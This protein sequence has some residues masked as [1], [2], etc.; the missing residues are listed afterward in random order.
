MLKKE[1]DLKLELVQ[2]KLR[3]EQEKTK[4]QLEELTINQELE[5]MEA[6]QEVEV[7]NPLTKEQAFERILT[8][9]KE[10]NEVRPYD[11]TIIHYF[12]GVG[13]DYTLNGGLKL[14]RTLPKFPLLP[15]V[16]M[17]KEVIKKRKF[18]ARYSWTMGAVATGTLI[19]LFGM[20]AL[21][22][23]PVAL[24]SFSSIFDTT[25]LYRGEKDNKLRSLLSSIFLGKKSK[26][27]ISNYVDNLKELE[28]SK[29]SF[30]LLMELVRKEIEADKL[31]E[32][33]NESP[34]EKGNYIAMLDDG[35][36]V[37]IP[38]EKYQ[39]MFKTPQ[40]VISKD[41]KREMLNGL[42]QKKLEEFTTRE[43]AS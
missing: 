19:S 43:L 1:Y 22:F 30:G 25:R 38:K 4:L 3:L 14:V 26:K 32:I 23:I 41:E 15:K 35:R 42:L 16:Q 37:R 31:L 39:K 36:F 5:K 27:I 18:F 6:K 9:E 17:T 8:L 24:G 21:Y 33:V 40:K 34:D 29:E 20:S 7:K 10:I 2:E 13:Y 11:P 28:S 12:E